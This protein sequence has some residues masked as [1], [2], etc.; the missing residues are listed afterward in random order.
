MSLNALAIDIM[1]PALDQIAADFD[2]TRANDRQYLVSVFM[3]AAAFGS[4]FFGPVTD[5]FGRRMGI[6][7]AL[8]GYILMALISAVV[9][10]FWMLVT[11]RFVH[12]LFAAGL[13]VIAQ[14]IVRDRYGGDRMASVM[15]TIMIVF[16]II[17]IIAPTLGQF[18]LLAGNWHLIFLTLA[19]AAVACLIWITVRL[20]ETLRPENVVSLSPAAQAQKW[21]E[22]IFNRLGFGYMLASGL[23]IAA[24]FGFVNSAQQIFTTTFHVDGMFPYL[25][26]LI[27]S[28]TA[29]G[30]F[31]NARI[32]EHFGARRVGHVATFCFIIFSLAQVVAAEF[33]DSL[34]L[35]IILLTLN[36]SMVGFTGANFGSLAMQPFGHIA[37][38]AAS[39]Q[40][41]SRMLIGAV[42]GGYI[43]QM[44]DGTTLPLALGFLVAGV[45]T[46]GSVIF[47]E[48][49]KLFGKS[50]RELSNYEP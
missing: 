46:L 30:N 13:F 28:G 8:G 2:V 35:F 38:A 5:R 19:V 29:I 21:R 40:A 26:A 24:M 48:K 41:F 4:L 33:S 32:V 20:P 9:P 50:D 47:A 15:S 27:A 31:M 14:S 18:I 36:V 37:G 16:M 11:A 7:V 25:F 1:L 10:T 39:F 3:F 42:G 43:G 12:G 17:P 23:A 34:I 44:F 22:I 49:G 45:L 6:F